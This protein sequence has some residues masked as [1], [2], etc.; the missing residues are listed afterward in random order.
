ML[1]YAYTCAYAYA[2]LT[3]I[4]CQ[5]QDVAGDEADDHDDYEDDDDD[6]DDFDDNE[7]DLLA[8][9]DTLSS[10]TSLSASRCGRYL[11]TMAKVEMMT[12]SFEDEDNE[13]DLNED[14]LGRLGYS[15]FKDLIVSLKMWQVVMVMIMMI[16]RRMM[17][18]LMMRMMLRMINL[19]GWDTLSSKTSLSA[20]R[21]GR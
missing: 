2:W 14:N 12:K 18:I 1:A 19:A 21:R 16:M 3:G 8:G 11:M 15:E 6:F 4:L 10:K 7:D 5:P 17:M 9:W 13:D 20:S